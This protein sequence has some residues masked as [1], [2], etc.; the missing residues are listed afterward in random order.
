[1]KEIL[2]KEW[3]L[4]RNFE[5]DTFKIDGLGVGSKVDEIDYYE[6]ID[7]YVVGK[8]FNQFKFKDRIE[9]L[10]KGKGWIHLWTGASFE[11]KNG[12]VVRVKLSSSYLQDIRISSKDLIK[13][14][15]QQDAKLIEDFI[16]N[17][18]DHNIDSH[19]LG[20]RKKRFYAF[21]DP[22]TEFLKELHFGDFD[23][24]IYAKR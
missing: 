24:S 22:K 2:K 19:I 6:I 11:I 8:G 23:E 14:F 9:A 15:G 16:Y 21:F 17:I 10:K 7:I 20:Y 1:M 3:F 5:V 12:E 13:I 4:N 18:I